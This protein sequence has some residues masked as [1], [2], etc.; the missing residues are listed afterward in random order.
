[1]DPCKRPVALL[2]FLVKI[3]VSLFFYMIIKSVTITVW[4]DLYLLYI[5]LYLLLA[6]PWHS[7]SS[8]NIHFSFY[9]EQQRLQMQAVD[10]YPTQLPINQYVCRAVM[11]YFFRWVW[12]SHIPKTI[13]VGPTEVL[14]ISNSLVLFSSIWKLIPS[15]C[16]RQ[17]CLL[18][19]IEIGRTYI[20]NSSFLLLLL[21]VLHHPF[22]FATLNLLKIL[23]DTT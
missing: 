13:F 4:H 10:F 7:H 23:V 19:L 17:F 22:H 5:I 14:Q 2:I 12:R 20:Q 16:P 18:E 8:S 1:M 15:Y 9:L 11:Q 21:L 3:L 6:L